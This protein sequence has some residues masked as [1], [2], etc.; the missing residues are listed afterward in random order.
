MRLVLISRYYELWRREGPTPDRKILDEGQEPGATLDCGT[1]A[2]RALAAQPGVAAVRSPNIVVPV[3]ST[4]SGSPV[5]VRMQLSAGRWW[6]AAS[7]TSP[8]RVDVRAPGLD[9]A[10]PANLDRPGNRWPV[11]SLRVTDGAP[12]VVTLKVVEP[13]LGD[14]RSAHLDALVATPDE[15]VR[16]V[17]LTQAC[18]QYVDWYVIDQVPGRI[19]RS[20]L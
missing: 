14:G 5:G 7:Y 10:L 3:P 1:P 8:Y 16:S 11:G 20:R 19:R 13:A 18:G 4:I 12:T 6:L 15:S 17:P 2:G 9:T